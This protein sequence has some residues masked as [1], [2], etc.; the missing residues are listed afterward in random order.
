VTIPRI[1]RNSATLQRLVI[2]E[3][4]FIGGCDRFMW[5]HPHQT[6]VMCAIA[7]EM[8]DAPRKAIMVSIARATRR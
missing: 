6:L 1:I 5:V 3:F 4:N 2:E 7:W 8:K